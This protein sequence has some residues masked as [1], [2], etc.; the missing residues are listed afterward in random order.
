[1]PERS[2]TKTIERSPEEIIATIQSQLESENFGERLMASSM[3][4]E[5]LFENVGVIV[6]R[7][8]GVLTHLEEMGNGTARR[9]A[10]ARLLAQNPDLGLV[11]I[12]INPSKKGVAE[13]RNG[14]DEERFQIDAKAMVNFSSAIKIYNRKVRNNTLN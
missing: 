12:D 11:I 7:S 8:T 6:E 10:Q 1:M 13:L 4:S 14:D 9:Y 5:H 2:F 3:N